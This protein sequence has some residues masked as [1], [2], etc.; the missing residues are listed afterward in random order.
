MPVRRDIGLVRDK[1]EQAGN[2]VRCICDETIIYASKQETNP[3]LKIR[4]VRFGS[5]RSQT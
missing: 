4:E 5:V 2:S 3:T 1:N